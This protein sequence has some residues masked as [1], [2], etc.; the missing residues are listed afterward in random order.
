MQTPYSG[1]V[2]SHV[3]VAQISREDIERHNI[4]PAND[5]LMTS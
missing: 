5:D 1:L 2:G 3:V 4:A